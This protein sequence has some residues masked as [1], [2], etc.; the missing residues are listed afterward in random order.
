MER[1]IEIQK[2]YYR[3]A[4]YELKIGKKMSH[5]MWFIFPQI[6]GLGYSDITRFYEIKSINEANEY[7]CNDYLRINLFN[8]TKELLNHANHKN[9][10]DI[11]D[12]LDAQKLFSCMTL[13]NAV[14][15]KNYVEV[16][17]KK[18]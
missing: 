16:S 14:D 5:W 4:F 12:P 6:K 8:I 1:F 11:M 3:Q 13:F 18:F 15:K 17:L 10:H 7:L 9:I 2:I